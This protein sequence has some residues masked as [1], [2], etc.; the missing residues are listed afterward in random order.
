MFTFNF[1]GLFNLKKLIK[2]KQKQKKEEEED[3]SLRPNKVCC[4]LS[5]FPHNAEIFLWAPYLELCLLEH[6]FSSKPSHPLS[7]HVFVYK[8]S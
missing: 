7:I 4:L 8:K 1:M 3:Y 5:R 6:L 2:E